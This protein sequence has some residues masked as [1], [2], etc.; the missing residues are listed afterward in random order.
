M[1]AVRRWASQARAV[2]EVPQDL[3]LRRYPPFVTGGDLPRGDI[4]VFVFHSVEPETFE[5]KLRHLADNQYQALS[6][7]EYVEVLGGKRRAPERAVVL[8]FDDGRLS[9]HTQGLPLLQQYGMKAILFL[10]PARVGMPGGATEG[11]MNWDQALEL[12]RSGLFDIESHSLNHARVHTKPRLAGFVTPELRQGYRAMDVPLIRASGTDWFPEGVALGTPFLTFEARTSEALRFY[13]DPALREACVAE[14]RAAGGEGFFA[15]PDWE[16][17]LRRAAS[18]VRLTGRLESPLERELAI[19]RELEESKQ[20]IESRTGRPVRHLCYPWH[21]AGP[22]ARR[23]AAELGYETAFCGKVPGVP[24]TRP[25]GDL[26]AI[27]RLGE[28]YVGLLP[29]R[30]RDRLTRVLRRKWDRRRG[31]G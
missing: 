25:G 9:V 14:V 17:R 11:F 23:L 30:G 19:R 22:T 18:R 5:P 26:R 16:R 13:E 10:V 31:K 3:L 8:T 27:A 21:V 6:A 29:G 7:A 12:S 28:D 20:A 4:P 2:W 1:N 24:I 15:Q